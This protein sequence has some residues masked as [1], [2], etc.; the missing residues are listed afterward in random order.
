MVIQPETP[1]SLP[2]PS[3]IAASAYPSRAICTA[4][5]LAIGTNAPKPVMQTDLIDQ[6]LTLQHLKIVM[7]VAEW[8][9]MQQ[10]ARHI[11]DHRR[12]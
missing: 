9:S 8:G 10:A 7:A 12:S 1:S 4:P 11:K 5:V 6:R 2:T 3:A